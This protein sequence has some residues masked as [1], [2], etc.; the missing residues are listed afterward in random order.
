[1]RG[2]A[3]VINADGRFRINNQQANLMRE[4][5]KAAHLDNRRKALDE[6]FSERANTP[7]WLDQRKRAA[8]QELRYALQGPTS[9]E[10]LTGLSLNTLLDNLKQMQSKG[11]QGVDVPID[12]ELLKQINVTAGA[13][14]NPGLLKNERRLSW[15]IG[16]TGT[17]FDEERK[18][19]ERNLGNAMQ[20]AQFGKVDTARLKN[21]SHDVERMNEAL[22]NQIGELTTKQYIDA[23]NYLQQLNDAINALG[24]LDARSYIDGKYSAKGKT[25]AQLV[26]SMAGLRFAPATP[27]DER[28]YRE[29]YEKLVSYY[30]RAQ[31]SA[32]ASNTPSSQRDRRVPHPPSLP[33]LA[34]AWHFATGQ[35]QGAEVMPDATDS[36]VV[37]RLPFVDGVTRDVFEDADGRQC[38]EGDDGERVYGEVPPADEP[39]MVT[40]TSP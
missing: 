35:E 2:A 36:R 4:Q 24:G 39:V 11:Q 30:T 25:V 19:I 26:K 38:D 18:N 40:G 22:G 29:L 37:G 34:A 23:R 12:E 32:R 15:P 17:E 7:T 3:D 10:I 27:G 13:G 28:A 14:A 8:K 20:D 9:G 31:A 5:V 1:L 16:L 21:L 33:G 6:F